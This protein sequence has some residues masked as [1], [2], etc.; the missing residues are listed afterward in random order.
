M[1]LQ[2]IALRYAAR[3]LNPRETSTFEARLANDQVARDALS[4]AVRLS[5]AALGQAPPVPHHSFRAAIHERLLGWWPGWLA[6]RSYRGHP[7]AW[8]GL[9]ATTVA[10]CLIL[11]LSL[12]QTE[13]KKDSPASANNTHVQSGNTSENN[14]DTLGSRSAVPETET[15]APMPRELGV[16]ASSANCTDEHSGKPSVAEIWAEL[17]TPDHIEKVHEEELRWRH[18]LREMGT[19][20]PGKPT[21]SASINDSREP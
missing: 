18:K 6:R 2:S 5:A 12:A 7:I 1:L 4:E 11:G 10:V 21:P 3:D 13:L 14:R 19:I 20:H 8:A 9:G 16:V 17:S 15:I